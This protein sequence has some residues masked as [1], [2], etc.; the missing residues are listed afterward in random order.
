MTDSSQTVHA[1]YSY[2]PW[3]RR[4]KVSGS[5]PDADLGFTGHYFHAPSGLDLTLYRAYSQDLGRWLSRDPLGELGF[6]ASR[7]VTLT[8]LVGISPRPAELVEGP[9]LYS[10]LR[11]QPI[12]GEDKLGLGPPSECPTYLIYCATGDSYACAAFLICLAAGNSATANCIRN[13]LLD[14]YQCGQSAAKTAVDH[15]I[16]YAA[17]LSH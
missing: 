10:Y 1:E 3:G 8:Q 2:D 16:C 17:C 5:G 14:R 4:T 15:A 12:R 11:N 6:E 9:N 7:S 13:C